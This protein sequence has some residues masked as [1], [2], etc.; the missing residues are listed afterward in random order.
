[1]QNSPVKFPIKLISLQEAREYIRSTSCRPSLTSTSLQENIEETPKRSPHNLNLHLKC[2]IM[3]SPAAIHNKSLENSIHL[4]DK[5]KNLTKIFEKPAASDG[6][7]KDKLREEHTIG[8]IFINKVEYNFNES[9]FNAVKSKVFYESKMIENVRM[10]GGMTKKFIKK[11]QGFR[12][13][14]VGLSK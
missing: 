7:K 5:A 14:R 10:S 4:V 8:N 1:M 11:M 9:F 2:R 6:K 13:S 3:K 12:Y